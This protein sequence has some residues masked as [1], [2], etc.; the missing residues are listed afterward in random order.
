MFKI[1]DDLSINITRGDTAVFT[2][3]ALNEAGEN[4]LFQKG[5][6]VRI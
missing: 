1:N 5:D 2:V 6:V 4:H 3:N